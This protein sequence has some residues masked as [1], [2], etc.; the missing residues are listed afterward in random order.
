M[1]NVVRNTPST[2]PISVWFDVVPA[3]G[4]SAID[5]LYNRLDGAYPGKWR[6]MFPDAQSIKNWQEAWVETFEDEGLTMDEVKFGLR[7][8]RRMYPWPPS[9]AE[10]LKACRPTLDHVAAYDE[11]IIGLAARERGEVGSWSSLAV[12][13]AASGM[14]FEL[15]GQTFGA[16]EA[17]WKAALK[18]QSAKGNWE[19]IPPLTPASLQIAY[20][21]SV[22]SRDVVD[23]TKEM[24][25]AWRKQDASFDHLGWAKKIVKRIES[26]DKTVPL[27]V[28]KN[29]AE[30]L[31]IKL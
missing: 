24:R 3:L 27:L 5:H 16:I 28:M 6:T 1:L 12:F 14:A 8:C 7:E 11:A 31:G 4:I 18:A 2:A 17:R 26:G 9:S 19:P 23:A 13:W 15:R 20:A 22:A 25:A 21:P 10:F 29:A 30:A